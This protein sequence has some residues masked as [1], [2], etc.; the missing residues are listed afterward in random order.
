[1]GIAPDQSV[2]S[3]GGATNAAEQMVTPALPALQ[4]PRSIKL[5]ATTQQLLHEVS[6]AS[7]ALNKLRPLSPELNEKVRNTFLP[8]RVV[9]S[10]N[11]EGI[12]ATRRQTLAVMDAVRIHESV[13]KGETEIYNALKAHEFVANCCDTGIEF[14]ESLMREINKLL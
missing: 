1:M 9:A 8:D 11:M 10:L 4:D 7:E 12:M 2:P 14:S 6:A 13:G 5:A 3:T